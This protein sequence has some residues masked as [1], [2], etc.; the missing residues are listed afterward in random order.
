MENLAFI[1][2]W[3]LMGLWCRVVAEKRGRNT[4]LAFVMGALGG[5]LAVIIYYSIGDSKE[6]RAKKF[7]SAVDER[8]EENKGQDKPRV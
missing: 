1:F 3:L 2:I 4:T 7:Q 8:I 6:L 5:L